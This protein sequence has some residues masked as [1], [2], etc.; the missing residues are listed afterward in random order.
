MTPGP[1]PFLKVWAEKHN[2]YGYMKWK[3]FPNYWITLT[4]GLPVIRSFDDFV[5]A[6]TT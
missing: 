2:H 5:L 4:K 1:S 6:S 3:H